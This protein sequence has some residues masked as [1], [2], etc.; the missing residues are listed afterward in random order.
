M[1]EPDPQVETPNEA[2]PDISL[3]E[4]LSA[5]GEEK[6][7]LFLV[8]CIFTLVGVVVSLLTTPIYTSRTVIM[9]AQQGG[10]GGG[11]ASLA[12]S[13]LG[14]LSGVPGLSGLTGAVKSSEALYVSLMRSRSIQDSLIEKL[15]LKERYASPVIEEARRNLTNNVSLS[16]EKGSNL[17]VIEAQDTDPQFAAK[18]ANQQV[19]ELNT[20]LNRLAVTAAQQQRLYYQEQIK[21]TQAA[22]SEAET[23]FKQ[24]QEE[25]GMRL[26]SIIADASIQASL[27]MRAQIASKEVLI[28][29]MSRFAT[30]Q[31]PDMQRI[32]SEL[33]AL[34]TQLLKDELGTER[35][36]GSP[37]QQEA[38][39]AYRELKVQEAILNSFIGQF[40]KAKFEESREGPPIQVVDVALPP[41][42]RSR[43]QRW[44]MV[45]A[46]LGGG[47]VIG[48]VLALLK[49][50]LRRMLQTAY[51]QESLNALKRSW[52]FKAR[53]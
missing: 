33:A 49:A 19:E 18:L 44:K 5:L 47:I 20:L 28:H 39:Q 34:H 45:T 17:I 11:G 21:K 4:T 42:Q 26:T 24:A 3:L 16:I 14:A 43:P 30:A 31:H 15:K 38:L 37:L 25:S 50:Y 32:S 29:A 35:T 40:Q 36:T 51:G 6:L 27:A 41:E 52:S 53:S 13:T 10:V 12:L 7:T 46:F 8:T 22:R 1:S 9:P 48:L 23:R 2:E